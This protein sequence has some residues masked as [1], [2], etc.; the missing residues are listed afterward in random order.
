MK[1]KRIQKLGCHVVLK[2]SSHPTVHELYKPCDIKV[3]STDRN[4]SSKAKVTVEPCP[5]FNIRMV[6]APVNANV[7]AYPPTRYMGS[8]EKLLPYIRDVAS[9]FHFDSALDLFSGSGIVGYLFK[10][11]GKQVYSNDYMAMNAAFSK[12]MI[13]NNSQTLTEMDMDKLFTPNPRASGFVQETF[14]GL[15]YT[16]NENAV[17]DLL[18]SNIDNL[19]NNFKRSI[20]VSALV[21]ACLRKRARGIFTYTGLNRYDDGRA[22]LRISIKE[23][24]CNAVK[25]INAAIF[26]NGQQNRTRH[27][28]AMTCR[29]KA[30]LVYI[31]P[32]YYSPLSDNEYVRRYHFVEG[33]A[34]NW[35]GVDMQWHTKTKKFKSYPTPFNSRH[36]TEDALNRIFKRWSDS[37]LLV[38]YSSNSLPAREEI[39][40]LMS[41]YKKHVEVIDIEYRYSFGNQRTDN[42]NKVR[43]Y[44]FAGYN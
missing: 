29:L 42:R 12:A 24:F 21:R 37:I 30:D 22:D 14:S 15:Y 39:I 23:H 40:S 17:I 25:L 36:G 1:V 34:R 31:D 11:M 7:L 8:K 41:R 18:R 35:Q 20:A 3:I 26:D 27:G 32:P 19:P 16:D 9:K 6:P 44:L 4:I 10:T 33:L 38:S 28:D 13:E 5:R 2:N 43:E